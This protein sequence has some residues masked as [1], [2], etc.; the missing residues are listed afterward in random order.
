M[1]IY[2]IMLVF[3]NIWST[4]FWELKNPTA[5]LVSVSTAIYWVVRIVP[6]PFHTTNARR[7]RDGLGVMLLLKLGIPPLLLLWLSLTQNKKGS[8]VLTVFRV[9]SCHEND[10]ETVL[11]GVWE[12]WQLGTILSTSQ[13]SRWSLWI[14]K[15]TLARTEFSRINIG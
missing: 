15:R 5:I 9:T 10:D 4:C 3:K 8:V 1:K 6:L 13:R 14:H 2:P 7:G 12:C 11:K